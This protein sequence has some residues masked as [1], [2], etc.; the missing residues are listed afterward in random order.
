ML[1]SIFPYAIQKTTTFLKLL[2]AIKRPERDISL[3]Q[4]YLHYQR[5]YAIQCGWA[6]K[7]AFDVYNYTAYLLLGKLNTYIQ[8]NVLLLCL[9]CFCVA[10]VSRAIAVLA[11]SISIIKLYARVYAIVWDT[12]GNGNWKKSYNVTVCIPYVSS[13]K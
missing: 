12:L 2:N 8:T 13:E 1:V 9:T 3:R 6:F 5:Q 10:P 7:I 4:I 11:G